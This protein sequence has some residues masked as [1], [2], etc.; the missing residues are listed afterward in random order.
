MPMEPWLDDRSLGAPQPFGRN[1]VLARGRKWPR[2]RVP[3]DAGLLRPDLVAH[4]HRAQAPS[5]LVATRPAEGLDLD[6]VE[7]EEVGALRAHDLPVEVWAAPSPCGLGSRSIARAEGPSRPS[8]A[9]RV[10][11]LTADDR[12]RGSLRLAMAHHFGRRRCGWSS[13]LPA[14]ER[15]GS[16]RSHRT[17]QLARFINRSHGRPSKLAHASEQSSLKWDRTGLAMRFQS[18]LTSTAI[19]ATAGRPGCQRERSRSLQGGVTD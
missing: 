11:G 17:D 19:A 18:I 14:R 9:M 3:L 12:C 16:R 1:R 6:G 15:D 4:R 5:R 7:H 2:A 13:R 10:S 8:P